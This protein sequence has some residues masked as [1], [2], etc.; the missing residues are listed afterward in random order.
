MQTKAPPPRAEK[1]QLIFALAVA[2]V[3]AGVGSIGGVGLLPAQGALRPKDFG[4]FLCP[5]QPLTCGPSFVLENPGHDVSHRAQVRCNADMTVVKRDAF[6]GQGDVIRGDH[7]ADTTTTPLGSLEFV[8]DRPE[9]EQDAVGS[10]RTRRA[11]PLI[12]GV[13]TAATEA[14]RVAGVGGGGASSSSPLEDEVEPACAAPAQ[15]MAE[16]QRR[17]AVR[18]LPPAGVGTRTAPHPRQ[19][20]L[21]PGSER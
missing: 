6:W 21:L 16:L 13:V 5:L 9:S 18:T 14:L 8:L 10:I 7:A 2:A 17:L 12:Q 20:S 3:G 4:F 19:S 1:T 11:N 15:D